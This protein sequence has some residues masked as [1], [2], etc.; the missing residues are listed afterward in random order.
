MSLLQIEV[1]A[2]A[3]PLWENEVDASPVGAGYKGGFAPGNK[4]TIV[5]GGVLSNFP[6]AQFHTTDI[7]QCPTFGETVGKHPLQWDC[8]LMIGS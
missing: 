8:F 3:I 2:K 5:D 7:P 1:P 6:I 4:V